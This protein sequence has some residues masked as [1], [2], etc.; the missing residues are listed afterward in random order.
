MNA[1]LPTDI[2]LRMIIKSRESTEPVWNSYQ[3]GVEGGRVGRAKRNVGLSGRRGVQSWR[4]VDGVGR[5]RSRREG[6]KQAAA[7][8][9]DRASTGARAAARRAV[10]HGGRLRGFGAHRRLN[11]GQRGQRGGV[12]AGSSGGDLSGPRTVSRTD[13]GQLQQFEHTTSNYSTTRRFSSGT[14]VHTTPRRVHGRQVPQVKLENMISPPTAATASPLLL[15]LLH[16]CSAYSIQLWTVQHC[17]YSSLSLI[18]S[19]SSSHQFLIFEQLYSPQNGRGT[20]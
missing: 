14:C 8:A 6:V 20:Q 16:S 7:A 18:F 10:E 12:D 5:Q 11:D 17:R 13:D 3:S 19:F 9:S 15:T 2:E 4:V 1:L